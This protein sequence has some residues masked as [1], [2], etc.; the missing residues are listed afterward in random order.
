M[1]LTE[2]SIKRPSLIVV[3]FTTLILLGYISL[4]SLG[5]ELLP[6]F[7]VPVLNITTVYPG[8]NPSEVETGVTKIIEEGL[9]SLENVKQMRSTSLEGVSIVILE[10]ENFVDIGQSQE[11]AQRKLNKIVNQL[12]DDALTPTISQISSDEFPILR[13][14]VFSSLPATEFY[15]LL[16]DRIKPLIS[17]CEGVAEIQLIG[18]EERAVRVNVDEKKLQAYKLSILQVSQAINQ[19][20]LDFPT[21]EVKTEGKGLRV[22]LAG[23]YSN[24]E[25][26]RN[27]VVA[28]TQDGGQIKL[29]D[30]ADIVDGRKE[31]SSINRLNGTP[32][33][34]LAIRKQGNANA[35]AVAERTKEKIKEIEQQFAKEGVKFSLAIDLTEFT[36]QAAE[37]VLEDLILAIVIVALVILVFLHSLRDSAIVLLAIPCSFMPTFIAIYLAG[38]TLNLM[39]MLG[40]TLVVGILVDDSIVVIE[41]I[42]RHLHMGKSKR[43]AA[44]DGRNEIG[45]TAL[46]ITFVDVVVF[47]PLMLTDAG[48]ISNILRNFS[49]VIVAATLMSLFVCFTVTPWLASRFSEVPHFSK[50]SIW[51]RFNIW[52]ENQISGLT[53]FYV[54]NLAWSLKHKRYVFLVLILGFVGM[55]LLMSNGFIGSEFVSEGDRGEAVINVE[56]SKDATLE[57]TSELSRQAEKILM[58]M[59][60]VDRVIASVGGSSSFEGGGARKYISEI[61]VKLVPRDQRNL[62]TDEWLPIAKAKLRKIPG[63]KARAAKININ[64][65]TGV[66]IEIIIN[67]TESEAT[68]QAAGKMKKLVQNVAG[69]TDVKLTVEGGVP[70]VKVDIDKEKM[71]NLGLT[72]QT[73]GATLRNAYAGNDD[74][75][76][77]E[78]DTEYDIIVMLD[79]FDRRNAEDVKDIS[80]L[81]NQG[82]LVKLSQFANIS[83]SLGPSQLERT[84]RVTS[85]KLESALQGRQSGD[86]ATDIEA[87][88]AASGLDKEVNYYFIGEVERSRTGLSTIGGAFGLSLILI[89]LLMVALY[90]NYVYPIVALFAI[91]SAVVG[92]IVAL[93]LVKG[94]MGIFT[95]MGIVVMMGLVT[96]NSILIVDFANKGKSEGM[97]SFEALIEAGRERLRPIL[98]TTLAMVLGMLPVALAHGPGSEWKNGLGWVIIGGLFGSLML[99]V[100]LV[101]CVYLLVDQ[102]TAYFFKRSTTTGV[103]QATESVE[104]V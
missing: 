57:Y 103:S 104:S 49:L 96:K 69:T 88:I 79:G 91:P 16:K 82:R 33:I 44:L 93:A 85:V 64:G 86:V 18:G 62:T 42:H 68:L 78:N 84:N 99:T 60:E 81:N 22:R 72:V 52:T 3:I 11:D 2:L 97:T 37:A 6:K 100:F 58:E 55:M 53:H 66:P 87:A 51:G 27:L 36:I 75:K 39:T 28:R 9:S 90:D 61:T 31:L 1:T 59:P 29:R 24:I 65:T 54:K 46:S 7:T 102:I 47:L 21:G 43:Q 74:S 92:G 23:K 101:P 83:P 15:Q 8:A 71:A 35:V 89:Y 70:E 19:S 98:M 67:G 25:D 34:G 76:F 30:V 26:L 17:S 95:A 10:M 14:S 80:F 4:Q 38:F 73:V 48:V 13:Y 5:L 56:L 12:A 40:L 41:N 94:S 32:A 50:R 20:N 63:V 77:R 45:F